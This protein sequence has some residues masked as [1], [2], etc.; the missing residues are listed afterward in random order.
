LLRGWIRC[1]LLDGVA[2]FNAL[3]SRKQDEEVQL[4]AFDVLAIDGEDLRALLL[5]LR[6]TN[7]VRLLARRPDG[8]LV[9]PFEQGEIG[10][11]LFRKACEFSLEGLVSKRA[12]RPYRAGR[13][14]DW[15][16]MKNRKHPAMSRAMD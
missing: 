1:L 10:P 3:H 14:P 11:D 2:D 9:A 16:K 5:S 4:Y 7:L 6:K 13:S 8:I 12:D 15:V